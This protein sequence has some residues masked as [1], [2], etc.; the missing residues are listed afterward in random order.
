MLLDKYKKYL[1]IGTNEGLRDDKPELSRYES[2]KYCIE[3]LQ[4]GANVLEL[5]TSRSYVDGKYEGCNSDDKKYWKPNNPEFWDFGGGCFSLIFGQL[6]YNLT[7]LDLIASH[8]AR[9]KIM[10]D[11]LGIKCNHVVSD[12]C[13]FLKNTNEKYDLIYLDTCDMMP[14]ENAEAVQLEEAKLIVER[15]L[16]KPE[17]M[18]LIDDVLNLTPKEHGHV[19]NTLGK[20][21][22]SLPYLL[23]NGFK[24]VF[25]GYQY[26]LSR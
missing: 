16:L 11:S 7:T 20:S 25:K 8:I 15:N 10:T 19:N 9:C 12:S 5:G 24:V 18:L 1:D 23:D 22:K 2:F 13:E 4:P 26:I 6:G 17:G 14:V 21:T 3:K